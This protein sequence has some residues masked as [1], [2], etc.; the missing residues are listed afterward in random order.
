MIKLTVL[1]YT[2]MLMELDMKEHGKMTSNTAT[3]KKAGP[4]VVCTRENI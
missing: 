3:E 4:M 1:E 2:P